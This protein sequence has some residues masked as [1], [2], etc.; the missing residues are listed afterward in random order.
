LTAIRAKIP[1]RTHRLAAQ[2][3][4]RGGRMLRGHDVSLTVDACDLTGL[5]SA[6]EAA[7][8]GAGRPH[9][10]CASPGAA[11]PRTP[12]QEARWCGD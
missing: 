3:S 12:Q 7:L 4:D 1:A 8:L 2:R 6:G 11:P 10:S 5:P 9:A